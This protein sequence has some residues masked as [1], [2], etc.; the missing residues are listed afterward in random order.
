ML[1]V[2]RYLMKNPAKILKL[3]NGINQ[4]PKQQGNQLQALARYCSYEKRKRSNFEADF[5]AI[6]WP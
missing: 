3:I 5:N 1:K 2:V 6:I 4:N